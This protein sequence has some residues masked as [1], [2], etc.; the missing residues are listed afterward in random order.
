MPYGA[1]TM[2]AITRRLAVALLLCAAAPAAFAQAPATTRI[3]G[4]IQSL[5]GNTLSV[6]T[7][8]GTPVKITLNDPLTVMTVKKVELSSITSGMYV[9]TAATPGADGTLTA[10]EVLVFPEAGRGTGEGHYAWD[11]TPNS[12]MTNANVDAVVQGS[13]ANVLTLT[14]KG[15]SVKVA[16]PPGT[17]VVT[18][19]PASREDLKPG[20]T[21]FIFAATK[22]ADGTLSTGRITVSKDGVAPPM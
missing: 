6:T 9:G 21:V 16:V 22:A 3:R 4:T 19:V 13:A 12:S 10:L 7:R 5:E 1:I 11:L 15:G 14:H 17:P 8:E 2:T 18:P 20:Q